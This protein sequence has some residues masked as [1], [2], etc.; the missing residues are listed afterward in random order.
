M[1]VA[2]GF[3]LKTLQVKNELAYRLIIIEARNTISKEEHGYGK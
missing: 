1:I 2:E 3:I